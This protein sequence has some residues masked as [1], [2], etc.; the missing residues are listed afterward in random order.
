MGGSVGLSV[1]TTVYAGALPATGEPG[2]PD[3][4]AGYSAVF[5]AAA[6]TMLLGAVLAFALV[7]GPKERLLPTGDQVAVHLG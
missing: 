5:V 2:L 7:R 1:F 6:I 3:L 4:V